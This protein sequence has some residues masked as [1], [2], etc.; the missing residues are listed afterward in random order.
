[1]DGLLLALNLAVLPHWVIWRGLNEFLCGRASETYDAG[2]ICNST[3]IV[4]RQNP[5]AMNER[6]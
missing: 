2:G 4:W 3:A 5:S 1:M 6:P